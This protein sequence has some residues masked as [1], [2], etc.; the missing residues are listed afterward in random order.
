MICNIKEYDCWFQ[1]RAEVPCA[2]LLGSVGLLEQSLILENAA[3][4]LSALLTKNFAV[5]SAAAEGKDAG[6]LIGTIPVL[7]ERLGLELPCTKTEGFVIRISDT[8]II[9]AGQDETGAL[10]GVYRF[11][12]LLA[13]G[14]ISVGTEII[15]APAT[16]FRS[17]TH[18]DSI[19]GDVIRGYAGRSLFYKNGRVDYDEQ[20]VIDYARLLASIGINRLA[21]GGIF[22]PGPGELLITEAMLPDVARLAALFRPFGVKLLLNA[23]FSAPYTLGKLPTADP[24]DASVIDWWKERADLIYRYIPDLA[25][26]VVKA[27]SEMEPGPFDYGRNH[28]E[29]AN[30]VAAALAPH[31][32]ELVW[33]CFVYNC[34]QDWRDQSIDRAR[35]AYDMFKPLDGEFADNVLLQVKFGPY[36]FQVLEPVSPLFGALS[37]TRYT[38]ELQVTQEYTGQQIDLCYLPYKWEQILDFDT[39]HDPR[40]TRSTMFPEVNMPIL[41]VTT[42]YAGVGPETVE[43]AVTKLL[44]SQLVNLSGLSSISSVSS[45]ESSTI[46]LTFDYGSDLDAKA[47]DVRDRIDLVRNRLPNDAGSPLIR[48]YNPNSTPTLR[49]AVQGGSTLRELLIAGTIAGVS[50]IP[51]VGLDH[52]WT[53]HPLVQANLYGYGRLCWDP[54][55]SAELIA[56]EWSALTFVD[57]GVADTVS[58]LLLRSY[59]AYEKYNAPFGVCF[60]VTPAGHYG[61]N[62]EGY[63][64]SPWGTYHRA[65]RFAIGIDRTSSGTGYVTQYAPENA[66]FFGDP[67]TCPEQL[68][69]FF[70]RLRY[71]YVMK[72]NKTLLQNIYNTHFEGYDEVKQMLEMWKGLKDRLDEHTY[73]PVLARFERQLANAREWRDQIN[74]YFWRKT[75]IADAQGR[76]I[77]E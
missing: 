16:P 27:D 8:R 69:L 26:F 62:I 5:L 18:W 48:Q 71:D 68:I 67:A 32:G 76:N 73:S 9:I 34:V 55:L 37:K 41:T 65:G 13:L 23:K 47:N 38:L 70:H 31:G 72:N 42:S 60:M 10:Y 4:E 21:I 56:R 77:Y 54:R 39:H 46:T 40:S 24:L 19:S 66:A 12:A 3:A 51:N 44:E 20:R 45:Q 29:G 61:P 63:E 25:G 58:E 49:V 17:L 6:T 1:R 50:A 64:F 35:A 53:G 75:G 74:T 59:P 43:N 7:N 28:A 15:D 33:R 11:L 22:G 2:R 36:D 14:K 52:N 57:A 30:A